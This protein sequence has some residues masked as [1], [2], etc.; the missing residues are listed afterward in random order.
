MSNPG[1][2]NP[3]ADPMK[4]GTSDASGLSTPIPVS[5]SSSIARVTPGAGIQP[6]KNEINMRFICTFN[7]L[8]PVFRVIYST[9]KK[10]KTQVRERMRA[11]ENANLWN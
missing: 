11:D 6:W 2:I 1:L 3:M 7:L 5:E 9:T 10:L 8:L 4:M